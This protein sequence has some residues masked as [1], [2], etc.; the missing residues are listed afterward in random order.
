MEI[1]NNE[2]QQLVK[3]KVSELIKKFKHREDRY[4]FC[5]QQGKLIYFLIIIITL[6]YWYPNEI[7]FDSTFFVQFLTKKKEVR[8]FHIICILIFLFKQLLPIGKHTDYKL[9]YFRGDG[10]LTKSFLINI[11]KSKVDYEKFLPDKTKY[12]NL[13]KDFLFSVS[14]II[15]NKI[16]L[17]AFVDPE[18]YAK[19][20]D[21][22]KKKNSENIYKKW[23]EYSVNIKG[24]M[25]QSINQYVP[26]KK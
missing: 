17:I 15:I 7:G 4:N 12:E 10:A 3:V 24:D 16:Q 13:S 1:G 19:M 14:I 25:I 6:G 8:I 18:T 20:Y 26:S 2:Q 11:I 5:R 22:Y 23:D 21:L 9:N